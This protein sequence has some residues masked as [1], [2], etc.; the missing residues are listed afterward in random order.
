MS[1]LRDEPAKAIP[2]YWAHAGVR[3]NCDDSDDDNPVTPD[4][5]TGRYV[6]AWCRD[7]YRAALRKRARVIDNILPIIE[8]ETE[9]ARAE[10][11]GLV[12]AHRDAEAAY[13]AMADDTDDETARRLAAEVTST[14]EE[15]LASVEGES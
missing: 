1:D 11:A 14:Y 13:W 8:R 12:R 2:V 6:S 3:C 10:V 9:R 7:N 4:D 5:G 15:L